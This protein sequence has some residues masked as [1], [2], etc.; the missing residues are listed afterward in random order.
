MHEILVLQAHIV[1]A[2]VE[3]LRRIPVEVHHLQIRVCS[4]GEAILPCFLHFVAQGGM[5]EVVAAGEDRARERLP[6]SEGHG[7]AGEVVID[8]DALLREDGQLA[9]VDDRRA[10]GALGIGALEGYL[11]VVI[12][13]RR[14]RG[15][16]PGGIEACLDLP[17]I[18]DRG[19]RLQAEEQFVI[20]LGTAL[21]LVEVISAR[22]LVGIAQFARPFD[23]VDAVFEIGD[24]HAEVVELLAELSG[25]AVDHRL[26]LGV[27][28][29]LLRHR[30][31]DHLRHL[32]AR[33]LVLAAVSAVAVALDDAVVGE[34]CDSVVCPMIGRHIAERVRRCER[35]RGGADD[36]R[37][38]QCGCERL[39]HVKLLL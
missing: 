30:L 33:D 22:A 27:R 9:G 10:V 25:E 13:I 34:L 38:R 36:E 26:L 1:R 15:R 8:E 37:C 35:R 4:A 2:D 11:A 16:I 6:C 23:V 14:I 7:G 31:G 19:F 29:I 24:A 21:I 28:L 20:R 39:L 3:F 12:L 17:V 32:V 5:F 18:V